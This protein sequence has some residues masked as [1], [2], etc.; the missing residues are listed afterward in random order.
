MVGM[1][2]KLDGYISEWAQ[3]IVL[4]IHKSG[5]SGISVVEKILRD[6]GISTTGSKHRVLWWPRN[7]NIA[8]MSRAMHQIDPIWQIVLIIDSGYMLNEDGTIFT[9]HD[10]AKNSSMG[11]R[12]FNESKKLAK[13]KL[14]KIL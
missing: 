12:K 6:P 4:N 3:S 2:R 9:K 8:K 14:S 5:F 10:L 13:Q 1:S 11:V 7:K